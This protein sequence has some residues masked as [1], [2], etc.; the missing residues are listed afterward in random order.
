MVVLLST[1]R[2]GSRITPKKAELLP[3]EV[4]RKQLAYLE[5]FQVSNNELT[6]QFKSA[7]KPQPAL[8]SMVNSRPYQ[9][10]KLLQDSTESQ[11]QMQVQLPKVFHQTF[12]QVHTL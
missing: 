11:Y 2:V 12:Q 7:T 4:L 6:S 5:P 9:L 8:D 10:D 3:T 1:K